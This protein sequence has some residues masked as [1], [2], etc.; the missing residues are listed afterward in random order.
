MGHTDIVMITAIVLSFPINR[1]KTKVLLNEYYERKRNG[2]L[3]QPGRAAG[4]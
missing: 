3:A 1:L 4:F 2:L